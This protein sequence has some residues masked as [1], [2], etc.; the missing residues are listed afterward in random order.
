MCVHTSQC[1]SDRPIWYMYVSLEM[2]SNHV[3]CTRLCML[4]DFVIPIHLTILTLLQYVCVGLISDKK[5]LRRREKKTSMKLEFLGIREIWKRCTLRTKL[6]HLLIITLDWW[7]FYP[8]SSLRFQCFYFGFFLFYFSK[9]K[10]HW[11]NM[12]RE[13]KHDTNSN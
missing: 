3:Q 2:I 1:V 5:L 7:F 11:W 4:D 12:L 8:F 9:I 10:S 13:K 6:L